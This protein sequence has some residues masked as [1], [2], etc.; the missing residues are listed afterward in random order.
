MVH[1]CARNGIFV[2]TYL[3]R[4]TVNILLSPN[5]RRFSTGAC[6]HK[7]RQYQKMKESTGI[8]KPEGLDKIGGVVDS[9]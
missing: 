1:S 2:D 6:M 3:I 7:G 4:Y 5:F 8:I 9:A